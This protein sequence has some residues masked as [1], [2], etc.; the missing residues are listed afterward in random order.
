MTFG[1]GF[2]RIIIK[3]AGG[4]TNLEK[5]IITNIIVKP[6]LVTIVYQ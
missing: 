5:K 3:T 2:V 6:I 4:I 1:Q